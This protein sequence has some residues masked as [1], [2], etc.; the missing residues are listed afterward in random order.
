MIEAFLE[1]ELKN[2][3]KLFYEEK[4]K[5]LFCYKDISVYLKGNKELI[6]ESD[7]VIFYTSP[8][9]NNKENLENIKQIYNN[10][11]LELIRKSVSF[12][13]GSGNFEEYDV[14]CIELYKVISIR[15]LNNPNLAP[16]I[17][18][19]N[20]QKKHELNFND[21]RNY[22]F[23][24]EISDAILLKIYSDLLFW[25]NEI[26]KY[27]YNSIIRAG[28]EKLI[29]I[30]EYKNDEE[31]EIIDMAKLFIS[32]RYKDSPFCP[33]VLQSLDNIRKKSKNQKVRELIERHVKDKT[34]HNEYKKLIRKNQEH[35]GFE[36]HEFSEKEVELILVDHIF[37]TVLH[38]ICLNGFKNNDSADI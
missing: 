35:R 38:D 2:D 22:T 24:R 11:F 10:I 13:Y 14:D 28:F 5:Q 19:G 30:K 15:E 36:S 37:Y 29:P 27:M 17:K 8:M 25:N 23:T 6:S 12:T 34:K 18:I 33:N 21:I 7:T 3:Q 32:E 20:W 4:S 26:P 1:L 9:L 31:L 16:T